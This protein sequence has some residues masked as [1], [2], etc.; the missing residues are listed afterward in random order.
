MPDRF[1]MLIRWTSTYCAWKLSKKLPD[2]RRPFGKTAYRIL[3]STCL[4]NLKNKYLA[5][6][7]CQLKKK[8]L[9]LSFFLKYKIIDL[10]VIFNSKIFHIRNPAEVGWYR[11]PSFTLLFTGDHITNQAGPSAGGGEWRR[12]RAWPPTR[13]NPGQVGIRNETLP[14][15]F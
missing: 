8:N 10:L 12:G 9:F 15:V 7:K 1:V 4:F 3:Y 2:I 14:I 6:N 11:Y 13:G 5:K